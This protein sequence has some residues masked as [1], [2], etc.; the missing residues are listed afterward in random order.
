MPDPDLPELETGPEP[1]PDPK[2]S[3]V[4]AGELNERVTMPTVD[5]SA[6]AASMA[7]TG[8]EPA[9]PPAS[10]PAPSPGASFNPHDPKPGELDSKGRKYNPESFLPKK[11][12]IGR[13]VSRGGGRPTDKPP[14]S[15][16][17]DD[18]PAAPPTLPS[19]S[20][21]DRYDAAA[22]LY[23]RTFYGLADA[24]MAGGGEWLPEND[25]EHAAFR[26]SVAAYLRHKQSEDLPPGL[27]LCFAIAS[28]AGKRVTKPNTQT[29][30]RLYF[31][32]IKAKWGAWKFGRKNDALEAMP[33]RETEKSPL[34]PLNGKKPE[35]EPILRT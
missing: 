1:A 34:P 18:K 22:E 12:K 31:A 13:W 9:S 28:Y 27:A 32:W 2:S 8:P 30:L 15:R 14:A 35:A 17:G 24:A 26:Q 3:P 19:G 6:I 10:A 5:E 33:I 20:A 25:G 11:D 21:G 4:T 23:T 16:V 29:R 7:P